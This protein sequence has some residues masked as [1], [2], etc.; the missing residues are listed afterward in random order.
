MRKGRRIGNNTKS[1]QCSFN[2]GANNSTQTCAPTVDLPRNYESK[3]TNAFK[4]ITYNFVAWR[5]PLVIWVNSGRRELVPISFGLSAFLMMARFKSYVELF[6]W[7]GYE[8]T[9][10][11]RLEPFHEKIALFESLAGDFST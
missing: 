7:L 3:R 8:H 5:R 4:K 6:E 10:N 2:L 9:Q 1:H 11:G